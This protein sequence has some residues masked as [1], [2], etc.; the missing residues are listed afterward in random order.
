MAVAL[1][2]SNKRVM[3]ASF[4]FPVLSTLVA[5]ILPDPMDRISLKPH[6]RVNNN[7]KGIDPIMYPKI[8]A[9]IFAKNS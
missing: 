5:P 1:I 6:M 2:E 4:L 9:V 7:P 3:K 8:I